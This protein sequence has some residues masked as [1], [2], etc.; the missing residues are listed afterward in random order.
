MSSSSSVR[1]L[2][3]GAAGAGRQA[4]AIASHI[5]RRTPTRSSSRSTPCRRSARCWCRSTTD[6]SPT[7]SPTSSTTAA[8][9]WS[10]CTRDYLEAV[11][12]IRPQ[13]ASVEHFVALE[14]DARG[15]LDY[16]AL[17]RKASAD[18]R[19]AGDR[20]AR[21]ADHQLHQRH[22]GAA[23]GCDDHPSQRL[24]ERGR[25]A[26]AHHMTP[27]DRY[28]WTLPMFHANGW[29]FTWIVTAVGG[30]HVCLR[31]RRARARLRGS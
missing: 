17:A 25:H 21:P 3:R 30:T 13:L 4:R 27:A 31:K 23:Q 15:W 16:E 14:G 26:G 6:W 28:L 24:H 19:A 29:T 1:S 11:D 8:R 5:S 2:V 22:H 20:R 18:V 7:I 12:G 10:A 9:Q